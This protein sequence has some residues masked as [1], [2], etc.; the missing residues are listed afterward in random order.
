MAQTNTIEQG[1]KLGETQK[2]FFFFF[3]FEKS[4]SG[5]RIKDWSSQI[6]LKKWRRARLTWAKGIVLNVTNERQ[7]DLESAQAPCHW[8]C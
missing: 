5:L 4:V 3:F 8:N 2:F 1:Q 6:R 7:N